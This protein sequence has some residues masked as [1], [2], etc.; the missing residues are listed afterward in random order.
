MNNFKPSILKKDILRILRRK[1]T[2]N[3][4]LNTIDCF[5]VLKNNDQTTIDSVFI[6]DRKLVDADFHLPSLNFP[7][8]LGFDFKNI[9]IYL[10]YGE[11]KKRSRYSIRNYEHGCS[12]IA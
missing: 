5:F 2:K 1:K 10:D 8:N 12:I 6:L 11:K 4:L 9:Y 3:G 7:I